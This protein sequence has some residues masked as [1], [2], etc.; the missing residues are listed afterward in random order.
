[1]MMSLAS[2]R[3][4]VDGNAGL[5]PADQRS[6]CDAQTEDGEADGGPQGR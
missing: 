5:I 3:L 1:M 4:M 2:V 6:N